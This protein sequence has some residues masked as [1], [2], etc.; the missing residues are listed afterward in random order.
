MPMNWEAEREM[1]R[2]VQENE[3]LYQAFAATPDDDAEE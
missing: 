3:D 1:A 2:D